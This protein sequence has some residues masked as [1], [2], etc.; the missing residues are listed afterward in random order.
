MPEALLNIPQRQL[1]NDSSQ[2][3]Y[4]SSEQ[5]GVAEANELNEAAQNLRVDVETI[6]NAGEE[7]RPDCPESSCA[8]QTE[9]ECAGN[10][11][12]QDLNFMG[13]VNMKKSI[14]AVLILIFILS[15]SAMAE[16]TFITIGT[17]STGGVYYPVGAGLAK[18][19][20]KYVK[21]L[22]ADAQ[23]TGGTVHNIQ[24]MDKKEIQAATMDNNYYNAYNGLL[25]YKGQKHSYLRG[26]LPLYPEPVQIMVAKGSGIRTLK[27]FKGKRISIG[28]VASGTELSARELLKASGLDPEKDIKGENLGVG[29]TGSAFADKHIDA[30]IM[31]GSLGMGGVVEPTTLGLVE[32][33]D[34]PDEVINKVVKQSP[35]WFKF[36]IPANTYKGQPKPVKTYA[37]PN[38]VAVSA[39]ISEDFVYQ[40]TKAAFEHKKDLVVITPHMQHMTP[41]SAKNIMIPLH[42]GA[43]KYYKEIGAVK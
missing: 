23:S 16:T 37:G 5:N 2:G 19:W 39:E 11:V 43:L 32:F 42:P 27:D 41:E 3:N 12:R 10:N 6:L 8:A 26:M 18:I 21:D 9:E 15:S 30:A 34:I 25:K 17:G 29:D 4:N 40:M 28:A 36:T 31:L 14:L 22:K 20:T 35:Y 38:I 1:R 24:L 7:G 13:G 33:I